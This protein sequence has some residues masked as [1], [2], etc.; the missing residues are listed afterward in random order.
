MTRPAVDL[1]LSGA[2]YDRP[3]P[4]SEPRRYL[5]LCTTPR[6][7]SHRL[8]RALYDL[9]AGVPTE[10]F[11]PIALFDYA[12]RWGNAVDV[13]SGG[14]VGKYWE[15]VSY[16][17]TRNGVVATSL[18]GFQMKLLQQLLRPGDRNIFLHLY[19]ERPSEQVASLLAIYQTK[20]PFAGAE[21]D[22]YIPDIGEVSPRAIRILGQWLAMQN[23]KWRAF[24]RDHPHLTIASEEFFGEP[25]AVLERVLWHCELEVDAALL[26][27]VARSVREAGAYPANAELKQQILRDF[28]PDFAAL[29][30]VCSNAV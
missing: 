8:G 15:R 27:R 9:G 5:F 20:R 22:L 21:T 17:R 6:S 1:R 12:Q 13:A 4:L 18:F 10:Y 28:A 25:R 29:D 2:E 24:L 3:T 7:G 26:E 23:R 14:G 19:R 11:H 30:E 16:W